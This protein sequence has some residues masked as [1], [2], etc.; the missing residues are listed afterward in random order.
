[1]AR[2]I[3][4]AAAALAV[5]GGAVIG[6]SLIAGL[7]KSPPAPPPPVLEQEAAVW[8]TEPI[9]P[10]PTGSSLDPRKV[11]L[12]RRLF[13][14]PRISRDQT[15]SCASCHNLDKGGVD[16]RA[17]SI[18]VGG[19]LGDRNAPTVFNVAFN[20]RQFWDGRADTLE[21]Q[22]EGPMLN[23]K[24]MA[25]TWPEI[26]K[27]LDADASY[28][29][30]F[31]ALFPDGLQKENVQKCLAAFLRSLITPSRF[32]RYLRGDV[33]AISDLER[34]GYELFKRKGC[35]TCHQGTNAGGNLFSKFGSMGDYF[36][37]RGLIQ[38]ADLGRYNITGKEED[39]Y[40]FKVPSLRNVEL[41]GPYFHDGS[42]ETIEEAV[43]IM[44]QY[45]LG[46]RLSRD[47]VALI[48]GFLKSLTGEYR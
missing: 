33:K 8:V 29:A 3:L 30:G 21:Q 27:T 34:Q 35:V 37:D 28:R 14:E 31:K 19:Q 25:N 39:K 4:A 45:Q 47:E 23:P 1:M 43:A 2:W 48:V 5:L 22:V 24:E 15:I 13:V 40:V 36:A 44:A 38:K 26:L 46:K 16:G 7:A 12:G 11:A 6:P 32:D 17:R 41:T 10:L 42:V 18:G 9:H 20:F